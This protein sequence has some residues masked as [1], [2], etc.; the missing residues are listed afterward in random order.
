MT[1]ALQKESC[2]KNVH[3]LSDIQIVRAT[4]YHEISI[5]DMIYIAEFRPGV[6]VGVSRVPRGSHPVNTKNR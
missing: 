4:V 1:I 3:I 5:S 6:P 2:E